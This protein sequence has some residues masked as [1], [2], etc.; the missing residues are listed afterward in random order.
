MIL[1]GAMAARLVVCVVLFLAVL[2]LAGCTGVPVS[3][4][5]KL[6]SF[7]LATADISQLRVAVRPPV[8]AAPTPEKSILTA[9]YELTDGAPGRSLDVH[10][11]RAA[12]AAD[13]AALAQ[14]APEPEA[15]VVYEVA[16]GDL[17]AVR[18]YQAEMERFREAGRH[19]R[20]KVELHGGLACRLSEMPEGPIRVD[21][22]IHASDEIG[23]LPL[24]ED[25]DVRSG[26]EPEKIRETAPVCE[27][28]AGRAGR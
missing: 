19:G 17:A 24:A 4:Q 3:T 11:R 25:Y 20:G 15:L 12:H 21:L 5:W 18:A 27:K 10:V 7:A 23:W 22:F 28:T 13:R 8:W 26:A 6:R 14:L 1:K 16:P 2:A 9:G